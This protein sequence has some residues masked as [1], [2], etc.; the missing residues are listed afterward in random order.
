MGTTRMNDGMAPQ[1]EPREPGHGP[2][3]SDAPR[4]TRYP[5]RE[6]DVRSGPYRTCGGDWLT[7]AALCNPRK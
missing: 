7:T 3:R 5:G 4:V 1:E 2:F 6:D